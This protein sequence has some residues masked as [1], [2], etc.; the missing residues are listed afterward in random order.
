MDPATT[1]ETLAPELDEESLVGL[2][3]KAAEK[4]REI[5]SAEGID[6]TM[7]LRMRVVGGGC[8]GFSYDLTSTR[9]TPTWTAPSASTACR[10]SSTR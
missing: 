2:T 4:V 6:D 10:S 1:P 7:G 5:K 3:L 8:S 9:S